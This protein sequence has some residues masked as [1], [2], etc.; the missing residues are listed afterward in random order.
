MG[1]V[2]SAESSKEGAADDAPRPISTKV[3][4]LNLISTEAPPPG[5]RQYR[6]VTRYW[7][8]SLLANS[9]NLKTLHGTITTVRRR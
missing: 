8:A 5:R 4:D 1:G 2:E 3:R 6:P 9:S 7:K